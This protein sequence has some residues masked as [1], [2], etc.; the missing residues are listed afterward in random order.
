FYELVEEKIRKFNLF[1][2]YPPHFNEELRYYELLSTRFY[3]LILILSLIILVLYI[4]VIDHTQ[5]VIIKSPTSK[6]YTL[7]YEQH[8]STLLC[9]CK[10]LSILYS[11]FLQLLP[12]RH[13]ICTSQYVTDKWIQHILL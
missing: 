2:P 12:E 9:R 13:E 11:K 6:Q 4:S 10:K 5:T 8:S 3:I 7:L 1:E